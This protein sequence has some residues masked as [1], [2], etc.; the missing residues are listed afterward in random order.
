MHL[1]ISAADQRLHAYLGEGWHQTDLG[2]LDERLRQRDWEGVAAGLGA[3]WHARRAGLLPGGLA[4]GKGGP[5]G[6]LSPV[7]EPATWTTLLA[8]LGLLGWRAATL[9]RRRVSA[10]TARPAPRR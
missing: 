10:G 3:G 1:A 2:A 7:P 8:G 9:A 6:A 5:D 4:Y